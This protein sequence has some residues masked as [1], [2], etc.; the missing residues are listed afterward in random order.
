MSIADKSGYQITEEPQEMTSLFGEGITPAE[1]TYSAT[2][3]ESSV[4]TVDVVQSGRN[5]RFD[6]GIPKGKKGDKGDAGETPTITASATVDNTTGTPSVEVTKTETEEATNFNF[7]FTGLKG[8]QGEPGG[9]GG[10]SA[11]ELTVASSYGDPTTEDLTSIYFK[12]EYVGS[13]NKITL[14]MNESAYAQIWSLPPIYESQ[15][16]AVP[17]QDAY[18]GYSWK[19]PSGGG[20]GG[21]SLSSKMCRL[22]AYGYSDYIG[23]NMMGYKELSDNA[24]TVTIDNILHEND[25]RIKIA[26]NGTDFGVLKAGN[27]LAGQCVMTQGYDVKRSVIAPIY[28]VEND[29]IYVGDGVFRLECS[30]DGSMTPGISIKLYLDKIIKADNT[31]SSGTMTMPDGDSLDYIDGIRY[32]LTE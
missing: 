27:I 24:K 18:G 5:A 30:S 4:P 31:I 1:I 7:A 20:G 14:E 32:Y 2:A 22:T 28:D 16:G 21:A 3:T 12:R 11:V 23:L 13:A 10:G 6:F 29:Y 9:G 19:V 8:P 17:T 25:F 26:I 15:E